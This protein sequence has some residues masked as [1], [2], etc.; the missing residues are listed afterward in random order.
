M[1]GGEGGAGPGSEMVIVDGQHRL[2]ACASLAASAGASG[3]PQGLD[4]VT[5]EVQLPKCFSCP[6]LFMVL[7]R[8]WTR[9]RWRCGLPA[10][11][12]LWGF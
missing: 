12:C 5:V 9:S 6:Y 11:L 4:S 2:G 7:R 10:P 8:A 3:L 1:A